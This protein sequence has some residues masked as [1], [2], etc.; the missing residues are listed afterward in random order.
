MNEEN[1]CK[2]IGKRVKL[3]LK[4]SKL[5]YT[6]VIISVANNILIINDKYNVDVP[7]DCSMIGMIDPIGQ[8]EGK[9]D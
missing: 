5:Q 1:V 4:D 6:G 2:Y 3:F 9:N 7:I 8:R